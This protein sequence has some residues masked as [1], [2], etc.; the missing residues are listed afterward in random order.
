MHTYTV[1]VLVAMRRSEKESNENEAEEI[2]DTL[3]CFWPILD[4][5]LYWDDYSA[6]KN[7][8]SHGRKIEGIEIT[9][10]PGSKRNIGRCLHRHMNGWVSGWIGPILILLYITYAYMQY[11]RNRTTEIYDI[12]MKIFGGMYFFLFPITTKQP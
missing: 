4:C 8:Q 2:V 7:G 9:P 10:K 5:I 3:F 12:G 1:I 6:V 11:Y